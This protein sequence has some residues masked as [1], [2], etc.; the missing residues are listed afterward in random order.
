M[1]NLSTNASVN[2]F[3][4]D[5]IVS[6]KVNELISGDALQNLALQVKHPNLAQLLKNIG[7]SAPNYTAMSKPLDASFVLGVDGKTTTL[8]NIKGRLAGTNVSGG[9]RLETGSAKPSLS[10]DL[11]FGTLTLKTAKR[12]ASGGS[13]GGSS[14]SSGGKWS[15]APMNNGWLH[16]ANA[17]LNVTAEQL[18][19]ESWTIGKPSL[20]MVM[21]NGVLD[22]QNLKGGLFGGQVGLQSKVSA[23][24]ASAPLNVSTNAN[25]A[26]VNIGSLA[27]A[28]SGTSRLNGDGVVSLDFNVSGAG[29][30]QKALIDSLA[31]S[32]KL[33]GSNILLR[34]FDLLAITNAVENDNRE[35][36]LG[37]LKSF[38]RGSTAFE[39][40]NGAY[41]IKGGVVSI[42]SMTLDGKSASITSSGSASMPQWRI[43]TQHTVSFNQ[44]DKLDPFTFSIRGPLDKPVSTFA[45]IGQDILRGQAGRFVQ[46]QLQGTGIGDALS[47]F[48]ILPQKQAPA[49][50]NGASETEP[51]AG[52][53]ASDV[54]NNLQEAQPKRKSSEEQAQEAIEGVLKG[55]FQ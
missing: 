41:T 21:S 15:S 20:S 22:I 55:L 38:S 17:N 8:S 25:I 1:D 3:G 14:S 23:A 29:G 2:A 48:G 16:S 10:G 35:S 49:N 33:N 40:L 31:G 43:D 45:N 7:A 28:L 51:A 30:S 39:A 18:D 13:S 12:A 46:E 5:V 24:S 47:R 36:L 19:Y 4:A 6:G 54:G 34:G 32:A 37:A 9:L 26:G 27:K 11:T 42:N 50:D 52:E 44:T 53:G